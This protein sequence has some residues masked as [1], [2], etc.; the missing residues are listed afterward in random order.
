MTQA[1]LTALIDAKIRNKT[2]KVVKIEHADVEQAITDELFSR[3]ATLNTTISDLN[4]IVTNQGKLL[5]IRRGYLTGIN[6]PVTSGTVTSSGDI[7]IATGTGSGILVTLSTAMPST[8]YKVRFDVESLGGAND[9]QVLC[10][11][12][13]KVSTTQFYLIVSEPG[14]FTQ[15]LR[16]H[17]EVISLD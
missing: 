6:L 7:S 15:N 14:N 9:D 12:F 2:P 3:V 8:N 4:T 5:P 1:E 11:S 13:R 10:P 16:F 17:I